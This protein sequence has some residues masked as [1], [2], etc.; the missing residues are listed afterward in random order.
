MA[1]IQLPDALKSTLLGYVYHASEPDLRTLKEISG[2]IRKSVKNYSTSFNQNFQLEIVGGD[3]AGTWNLIEARPLYVFD[4][5]RR[6][7]TWVFEKDAKE[8]HLVYSFYKFRVDGDVHMLE[9]RPPVTRRHPM[10]LHPQRRGATAETLGFYSTQQ[11]SDITTWKYL[12]MKVRC[13]GN[14]D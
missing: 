6:T 10:S 9:L 7:A 4:N 3:L 5:L 12:D 8:L 13:G 14:L 11:L 1:G 2:S